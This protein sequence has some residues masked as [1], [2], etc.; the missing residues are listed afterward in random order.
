[1]EN[2]ENNVPLHRLFDR[3]MRYGSLTKLLVSLALPIF[4]DTLLVMTLGAADTFMLSRYSDESVAA[5]GLV[6]QLVNIVF[7]IFQVISMA[8]SI[9]C[10]QYVGAGQRDRVLQVMGISVLFNFLIGMAFSAVLYGKATDLLETMGV[11]EEL[12]SQSFSYMRIVGAFAFFQ[13]V[14][15][16]AAAALRSVDMAHYPMFVSG[17]VNVINIVGNYAL[18]FGKFGLPALGVQGA[19]I[20]TVACRALS[21]VLLLCLLFRKYVVR[22]PKGLFRPFPWQEAGKLFK[23]GIPSAGEQM[24]YSLS[25]V[26]V[27]YFINFLGNDELA[28]RTYAHTITTFVYLFSLA[29]AQGGAIVI[30]HLTGMKKYDAAFALG[31]RVLRV[32]VAVT[33]VLSFITA[34]F[35]H[36]IFSMLSDNEHIIRMGSLVLWVDILV[37]VGRAINLFGVNSLRSAGDI[38]Y[39][40]TVGIIVC[41]TVAVGGSWLLGIGLHGGLIALWCA[42]I[43]DEN[44]RGLI[45]IRRWKSR[46]W[47]AKSLV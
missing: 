30:G 10:S 42:L 27:T 36:T 45:F 12:F 13:A 33:F 46:R 11:R 17:L 1:M 35:G 25:M 32:S 21:S 6:N 26:V 4:I 29:A 41:W 8:T 14:S 23:V 19:A 3:L 39:P 5:V 24:S 7:I 34:C 38:Y 37:E 9:L 44:I 18:I 40:V 47:T 20:S 2:T 28:T 22:L 16:S 31:R 15:L 43:L